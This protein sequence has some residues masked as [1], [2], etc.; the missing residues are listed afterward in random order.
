[1]NRKSKKK[2]E[3]LIIKSSKYNDEYL[4]E[5]LKS[6]IKYNHY[7]SIGGIT[8]LMHAASNGYTEV[9]EVL[10]ETGAPLHMK[11]DG[12]TALS[13]AVLKGH[14]D[15]ANILIDNGI[16]EYTS[17][18]KLFELAAESKSYEMIKM[19]SDKVP[20][21]EETNIYSNCLF[22]ILYLN[23]DKNEKIKIAKFLLEKGANPN[24]IKR[25]WKNGPTILISAI[26]SD[27]CDFELIKL[28][29]DYKANLA[30]K[31]EDCFPALIQATM[32]NKQDIINL[33]LEYGADINIKD[34][35]GQTALM[36]AVSLDNKELAELL[37]DH[38]ANINELDNHGENVL[39]IAI[40]NNNIEMLRFLLSYTKTNAIMTKNNPYGAN[41]NIKNKLKQSP[42]ELSIMTKRGIEIVKLLLSYGAEIDN[43]AIG[44]AFSSNQTEIAYYLLSK[45]NREEIQTKKLIL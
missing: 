28:L 34:N 23:F 16:L 18:D 8:P 14:I 13:Y 22:I 37:L 35:S 33:L 40:R 2:L 32:K 41:P 19:I 10:I 25:P 4:E 1:M 30:Y 20:I 45:I 27:Y 3:E 42:L 12:F 44:E 31:G 7:C 15:I 38:G 21:A 6:A 29:L 36:T 43:Q 17:G 39:Y 24:Y 5:F 26:E 11:N 9:V